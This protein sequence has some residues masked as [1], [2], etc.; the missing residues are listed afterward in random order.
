MLWHQPVLCQGMAE[1]YPEN[2]K[3]IRYPAET[4]MPGSGKDPDG[5]S[6]F[7]DR[8]GML[9]VLYDPVAGGAD[10]LAADGADRTGTSGEGHICHT[11][12]RC[13]GGACGHCA[14]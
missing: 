7:M 13:G 10:A 2:A 1:Q 8:H 14:A 9:R 4:G 12:G 3:R 11:G 5:G 6:L